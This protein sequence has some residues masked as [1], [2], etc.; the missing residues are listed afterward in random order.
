[1]TTPDSAAQ[2]DAPAPRSFAAL[3][4][5]GYRAYFVGA[6]LAMM[7]DSIEHVISYWMIFDKFHSPALG[8][9]A[10]ISHWLPF[11]LFS[12]Y[13]GALADRFDPRR[14]IQLGMALFM[15]ASLGWGVLFLTDSLEMW[16][17]VVLLII[18]GL[19]GVLWAPAAQLLIHDIVGPAQLQSAVRLTATSRTLGLLLGPA[20]GGGMMLVLGPAY[21]LL[22]NV[23]IYLPFALWLWKAPYGPRFREGEA[24]RRRGVRGFADILSTARDIAGNRTIVSMIVLAG[25]AAMIVG[26]AHQAQMPEFAHDLGARDAGMLYSLLLAA[27]AAGAVTAGVVLESRGLL[28]ARPRTAIVLVVLWCFAV[29]GFAM[30]TSYPLALALLLVAGFLDLSFNTMAQTLVQLNAPSEI[31]GRVIGLYQTAA[32]GLRAFSGVTIGIGGSLIGIHW[33]LGLSA[34]VLLV[35]TLTL[36]SYMMRPA[37]RPAADAD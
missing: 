9:F 19:A 1:M 36:L 33:S 16:H 37:L 24:V 12:V 35:L 13:A 18:H 17:A 26:N 20:I 30:A 32:L 15:V 5:P 6:A 8:G 10:V 14:V 25:G 2:E 31:R 7:A 29:G 4:H 34:A 23:L 3:R 11:L 22:L 27:N 21:G 28:P